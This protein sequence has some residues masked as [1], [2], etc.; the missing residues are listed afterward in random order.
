MLIFITRR[1]LALPLVMLAV[2]LLTVGLMQFL[3]PQERAAAFI[4]NE[5][6]MR[7]IDRV[8]KEKGL[9]Q[10]FLVQ[11]SSWIQEAFKGNLGFSRASKRSVTETIIERFPATLELALYA[12]IP[13][14]GAGIWLGTISSLNKD[15]LIDQ[16]VRVFTVIGYCLPTFVV[17]I[18]LL[19]IFYGA[20]NLLPGFGRV[21]SVLEIINPV[22]RVTGLITIDTILAGQWTVLLD[23]IKHMILPVFTLA[24]VSSAGTI[25]VMRAQMLD[26]LK[27]D[28]VRTARAKGLS[29]RTVNLKHARRNALLP[30]VTLASFTVQGLLSGAVITET[31][32]AYP[33]IG[34][35]GAQAAVQLDYPGVLGFAVF[36]ALITVVFNVVADVAYGLVDPRVRFD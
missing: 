32:F 24:F 15:K 25:K 13:L 11:Y 12:F 19:V 9:D 20:L 35:W 26:V 6:Q 36:I 23:A 27:S 17:G 4:T 30:I 1:L 21:D 10:P 33:G 8:I 28:Y 18:V 3:T 2:T 29:E 7:N 22:P 5:N 14:I 16:F 31:I 34:S